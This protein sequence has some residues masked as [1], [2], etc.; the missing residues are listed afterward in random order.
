MR[1]LGLILLPILAFVLVGCEQGGD[2]NPDAPVRY[3]G[4]WVTFSY[5]GS[6]QLNEESTDT[7]SLIRIQGPRDALF[8]IHIRSLEQ[9]PPLA[10]H[11]ASLGSDQG[12]LPTGRPAT[13]GRLHGFTQMIELDGEAYQR[14]FHRVDSHDE[15]AY[16]VSQAP[17]AQAIRVQAGLDRIFTTFAFQ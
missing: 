14:E 10:I 16:L 6:W 13:S 9:A 17:A 7:G 2:A 3:S 12:L 15:A 1:N 11:A 8:T 4:G 5:P